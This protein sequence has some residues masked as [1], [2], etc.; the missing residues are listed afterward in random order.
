MGHKTCLWYQA[1]LHEMNNKMM[2]F[3]SKFAHDYTI[4]TPVEVLWLLFHNIYVLTLIDRFV[5]KQSNTC[6]PCISHKIK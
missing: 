6:K 5:V 2:E 1:D 4:E 3:S